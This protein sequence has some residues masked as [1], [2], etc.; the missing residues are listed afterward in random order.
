VS[1]TA[2][3]TYY[4]ITNASALTLTA[5]Q[6]RWPRWVAVAGLIGCITLTLALPWRELAA[7][8]AV[9]AVGALVRLTTAG[10]D[11]AS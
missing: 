6:R 2:I 5:E 1:G 9:L 4:A 11:V 8:A 3:L 7:G 10:R